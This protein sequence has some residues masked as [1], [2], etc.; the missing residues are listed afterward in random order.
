[1]QTDEREPVVKV[2]LS[3]GVHVYSKALS[4][5]KELDWV[6]LKAKLQQRMTWGFDNAELVIESF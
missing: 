1:M 3:R 4:R 6:S 2:S 5:V